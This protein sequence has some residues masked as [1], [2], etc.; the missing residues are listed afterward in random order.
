MSSPANR[1]LEEIE[2]TTPEMLRDPYSYYERLRAEAP[3]FRDPKTG[4]V[5]VSTYALALEVN[6]KPKQF[7]NDFG[8]LLSTG[9]A[10]QLDPEE[11]AVM[12]QGLAGTN[13][14]LTADP[15][16]HTRYKRIAMKAFPH[17]RVQA[18][19]PYMA[20]VSNML[21]DRFIKDGEV[22]LKSQFSDQLPSIVIADAL[23][24]KRD[25][26]PQFQYWLRGTIGK[27]NGNATRE[28]RIDFAR[29]E[30]ELQN[31]FIKAFAARRE[32]PTD[33]IVSDLVHAPVDDEGGRLLNDSELFSIT[34][35]LF[36][37]G[38]EATSHALSY[39]VYQLIRNPGEM[40]KIKADPALAANLVEET[41][42]HLT[43]S[44]NMWRVVKEDT[45]LGGV[46]LKA[47]EPMW[48][49]YG[50]ANR[51]E[52]RFP[53]AAAFD[54]TRAN[55][56]EHLGFGAGI[57]TCLGMALARQEMNTALPILIDRLKNLRLADGADSYEIGAS[58]ILRGVASLKLR[59]DPT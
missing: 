21:I 28:E 35:Q 46:A 44:H 27:L 29:R 34:N 13:T 12:E 23:G 25:E 56:R 58:T 3:V 43:P 30:I 31:Y 51:D 11:L 22:E 9:G 20:E 52:A 45:E 38:Q 16:A 50:S 6:K 53:D 54:I 32:T 18:M 17:S 42:R 14:M 5:S 8:A 33:D 26:I 19:A 59:F 48:L 24:A 2:T 55:A 47:G 41:V 36:S 37:A 10:G 1:P 39:A 40:T 7:S 57:H 4:I 49:R 15:P